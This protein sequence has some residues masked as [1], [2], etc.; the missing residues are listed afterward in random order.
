MRC[1]V[2]DPFG[3]FGPALRIGAWRGFENVFE[4]YPR[5]N[6]RIVQIVGPR[7]CGNLL[8]D[9]LV[10]TDTDGYQVEFYWV[11]QSSYA[12]RLDNTHYSVR[13]EGF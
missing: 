8:V 6:W 9:R 1:Y 3:H 10:A 11:L 12:V 4:A 5:L 13:D 7:F 2:G